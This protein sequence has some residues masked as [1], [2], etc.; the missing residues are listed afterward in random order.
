MPNSL[1]LT[2]LLAL[3]A[4]A[5]PRLDPRATITEVV[6]EI[7]TVHVYITVTRSAPL[8]V[9]SSPVSLSS[10]S[11]VSISSI[12]GNPLGTSSVVAPRTSTQA[13]SSMVVSS[14]SPEPPSPP[15]DGS[16]HTSGTS[17]AYLVGGIE[18]K[19]AIIFHHNEARANHNAA[20]L[21]WNDSLAVNAAF[22]AN[23]CIFAHSLPQG[24]SNGQNLF[25]ISGKVFNVTAGITE[26]WYK[27]EFPHM[28]GNYGRDSLPT[29]VFEQVGHLTQLLW[30]G[31]TSVG[32]N[33]VDCG[34]H[35]T[36]NG[37]SGSSLN[38]FTACNYYPPGNIAGQY[39]IS[40]LPPISTTNLGS[41]TD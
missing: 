13:A 40:V 12:A 3:G 17:Q 32:C 5:V 20:P 33:S 35:M 30:Q 15:A 41:W 2:S 9:S 26:S 38:K 37:A 29:A 31:T 1:V 24:V 16:D 27:S 4:V 25:L 22:T 7:Q 8:I 39:S 21:V 34:D 23:Q 6:T 14:P 28:S 18:Y 19:N 10:S 36:V 11:A